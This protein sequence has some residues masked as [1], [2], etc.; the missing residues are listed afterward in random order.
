M[1]ETLSH[2][3]LK[4]IGSGDSYQVLPNISIST[5][6]DDCLIIE[7][8]YF[9]KVITT[10]IVYIKSELSFQWLGRKDFVINSGGIKIHPEMVESKLQ[11]LL[12]P[13]HTS[14]F[15]VSSEPDEHFGERVILLLKSSETWKLLE[16]GIK[17]TLSKY[18]LPKKVYLV[19][20][21]LY[22]DTKKIK[23]LASQSQPRTLLMN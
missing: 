19:E 20:E 1:T 2:I 16:E 4:Q 8:D 3:A 22:T 21:F 7:S 6:A 17:S 13:V 23:R 5:T 10:D 12:G 15:L 18:E 11:A 14:P 9:D